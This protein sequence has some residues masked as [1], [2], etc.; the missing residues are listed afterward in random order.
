MRW[1]IT[2]HFAKQEGVNNVTKIVEYADADTRDDALRSLKLPKDLLPH[3]VEIVPVD[4][5]NQ[6]SNQDK[7]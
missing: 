7:S 4:L 5:D 2:M 3:V 6:V 1:K